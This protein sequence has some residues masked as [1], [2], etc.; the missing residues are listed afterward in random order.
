ME[1][2][3]GISYRERQIFSYVYR[4][5]EK[6]GVRDRERGAI[7]NMHANIRKQTRIYAGSWLHK[8]HDGQ[9]TQNSPCVEVAGILFGP[10]LK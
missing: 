8:E 10:L 7:Q 6:E 5:R 1:I 2:S 4:D 3:F 9:R